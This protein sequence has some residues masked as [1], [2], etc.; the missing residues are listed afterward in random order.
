MDLFSYLTET[1]TNV[2]P[3]ASQLDSYLSSK[4]KTI[5]SLRDYPAVANA[6]MKANST[7][8]SSA[9]V[10]R[11]FSAAGQILTSRRCSL[12]DEHFDWMVF[13][14]DRLKNKSVD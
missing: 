11:L 6:F 8:P 7:L 14:R 12:S 10:E 2:T 5:E 1:S 13:V 9:V 4:A 3:I